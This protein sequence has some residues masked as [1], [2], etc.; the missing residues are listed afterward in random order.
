MNY[1]VHPSAEM[2]STCIFIPWYNIVQIQNNA[3]HV[4]VSLKREACT[5]RDFIAISTY[6]YVKEENSKC[7]HADPRVLCV[8]CE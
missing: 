4:N 1:Q 8:T 5:K 6:Y 2:K 7:L 3:W